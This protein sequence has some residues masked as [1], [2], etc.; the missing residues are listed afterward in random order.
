MNLVKNCIKKLHKL[1]LFNIIFTSEHAAGQHVSLTQTA[2][3]LRLT[4]ESRSSVFIDRG[5]F[6]QPI[7]F[8]SFNPILILCREM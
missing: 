7:D 1:L 8:F 4:P 6:K 3:F 5:N 2:E